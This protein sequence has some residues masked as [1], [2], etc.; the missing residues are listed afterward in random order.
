M[1]VLVLECRYAA[2]TTGGGIFSF[3]VLLGA[4][5]RVIERECS[6][7][8]PMWRQDAR[9]LIIFW[10]SCFPSVIG[11]ILFKWEFYLPLGI[12]TEF[13]KHSCLPD[14]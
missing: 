10:L 4:A 13:S 3:L 14:Q 2:M 1:R 11:G 5:T 9:V 8:A 7:C 6:F 12:N